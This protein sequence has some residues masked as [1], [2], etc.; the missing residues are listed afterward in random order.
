[1]TRALRRGLWLVA[2]RGAYD[3]ADLLGW[4]AGRA[5]DAGDWAK[6]RSRRLAPW[7]GRI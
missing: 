2:C 1:M 5:T 3:L 7:R 4:L 6:R